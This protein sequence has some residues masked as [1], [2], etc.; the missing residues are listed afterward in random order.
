[1]DRIITLRE[2]L[3]DIDKHPWEFALFMPHGVEWNLDTSCTVLNPD[4]F[5]EPDPDRP[6]FAT[7]HGLH[8]ALGIQAIKSVVDNAKDQRPE[9]TTPDLVDAL[10]YYYDHDAYIDWA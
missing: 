7:D 9:A 6:K 5:N 1:M 10:N 4:D 8:Y 3:E 2:L